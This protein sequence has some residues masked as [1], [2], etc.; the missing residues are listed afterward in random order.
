M[1]CEIVTQSVTSTYALCQ[2]VAARFDGHCAS[3]AR[4]REGTKPKGPTAPESWQLRAYELGA[5]PVIAK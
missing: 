2:R 5:P 3:G 4:S 1:L